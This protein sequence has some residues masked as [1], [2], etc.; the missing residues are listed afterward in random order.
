MKPKGILLS[1]AGRMARATFTRPRNLALYDWMN[2]NAPGKTVLNLGSGIGAFDG[3][4]A[5]TVRMVNLDI[6]P[7]KPGLHVVGDAQ[8]LPFRD[9]SFDVVYSIAVLEHVPKPWL[10]AQEIAR[11]LRPGG[12]VALELPFLNVIHDEHDYFRFT[13]RGIRSLFDTWGIAPVFEQVGSGG[14]SFAGLFLLLYLRQLLPGRKLKTLWDILAPRPLSQFRRLDRFT[15]A[16]PELRLTA[17][18]FTFIGRKA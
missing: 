15:E 12:H 6:N 7:T 16:S 17:N 11:V 9:E 3:H 5:R 8:R 10:A 14:G 13:D 18:S 1:L 2:A 4:L